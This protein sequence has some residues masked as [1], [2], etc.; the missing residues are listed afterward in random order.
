MKTRMAVQT[1]AVVFV[2]IAI[3][4]NAF[5]QRGQG[6]G[7]GGWGAGSQYARLYD[8][9]TVET[10]NGEVVSIDYNTP[11]S[12]SGR[13]VHAVLK[14][15]KETVTVHLGPEWFLDNQDVQ[16][17]VKDSIKVTGSRIK[18]EGKP[19]IIAAQI[20]KEDHVLRLRDKDGFP[21]WAAWR[22]RSQGYA[23]GGWGAGSQYARLYDPKTV[24]TLDGEVVSIDYHTPRSA[25]GRGVHLTL[26]TDKESIAVHLGPEWFIEK[27]DVQIKSKDKIK[28]IGSRVNYEGKPAIIAA[29]VEKGDQVLNLRDKLGFAR[30][31]GWRP[32]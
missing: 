15:A 30:W 11:R 32:R 23:S 10:L 8:P 13:G 7:R 12:A 5:A 31:A 16:I 29:E 17:E 26:K 28:V 14:A 21:M 24:E 20:E 2:V 25:T 1:F 19:A 9:K 4:A 3:A 6:K 18:Y 27:Q 22:G